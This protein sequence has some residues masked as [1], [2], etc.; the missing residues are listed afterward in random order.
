M[1][2]FLVVGMVFVIYTTWRYN[3]LTLPI[4]ASEHGNIVDSL[5]TVNWYILGVVFFLTNIASVLFCI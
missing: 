4:S 5:M 3:Q 1:M 2:V